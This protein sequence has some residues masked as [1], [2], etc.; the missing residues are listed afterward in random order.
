MIQWRDVSW[1]DT[2][3]VVVAVLACLFAWLVSCPQAGLKSESK[4]GLEVTEAIPSFGPLMVS[5]EDD[6]EFQED[7]LESCGVPG[8]WLVTLPSLTPSQFTPLQSLSILSV[9]TP[10]QRPLR[11]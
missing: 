8:V 6:R 5:I 10:A 7:E 9:V 2:S 1:E 11:C 4:A 3:L